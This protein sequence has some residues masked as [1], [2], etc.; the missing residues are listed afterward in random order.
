MDRIALDLLSELRKTHQHAGDFCFFTDEANLPSIVTGNRLYCRR[1]ALTRGLI[2]VD[3]ASPEVL[4]NAPAWA[5]DYVRLY[6]APKTPMLYQTEG[7]K[8]VPD[9][10]PHCPRPVYL[11]FK[12]D[13]LVLRSARVSDGNLSSGYST[14]P[15]RPSSDY[16]CSLPFPDIYSRGTLPSRVASK[17]QVNRRRQAEVLIETE[18]SLDFVDRIIFRSEA[19]RALGFRDLPDLANQFD[20]EV[21]PNW[22]YAPTT[23][24]P[25]LNTF[26]NSELDVANPMAGDKL[27]QVTKLA[28]GGVE[29]YRCVYGD[30]GWSDWEPARV[31]RTLVPN[32]GWTRFFLNGWRVA[33]KTQ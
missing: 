19:E 25:Y 13:I 3:G 14:C 7:L 28:A 31:T 24:R 29:S 33:E 2:E 6:F 15:D 26:T 16:F 32:P 23:S 22:F 1:E 4:S 10:W 27:L 9:E 21:D 8:R 30:D 18:L 20:T 11:V 17:L 12:P 5:Q